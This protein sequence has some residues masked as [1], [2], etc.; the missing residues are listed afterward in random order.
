MTTYAHAI[1]EANDDAV[2]RARV[3]AMYA[4]SK[5]AAFMAARDGRT[6]PQTATEPAG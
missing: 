3:D 6:P 2:R 5:M 1:D 4:S